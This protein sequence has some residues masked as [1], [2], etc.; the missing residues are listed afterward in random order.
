MKSKKPRYKGE[1]RKP[2][3]RGSI[4]IE[5]TDEEP[6][7]WIEQEII[8]KLPVLMEHYGIADKDDYR[9]LALALAKEHVRGFRVVRAALKLDHGTWGA[10]IGKRRPKKWPRERFL[11][12]LNAVD[13]AKRRHGFSTDREAIRFIIMH[14]G[15]WSRPNNRDEEKWLETMESRLQDAKRIEREE[16]DGGP[17]LD[18]ESDAILRELQEAVRLA[19]A[20]VPAATAYATLPLELRFAALC[21]PFSV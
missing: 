6:P 3:Y 10:V 18:P 16:R 12:L 1:L 21:L 15:E 17:A 11:R 19:R 13:E 9:S 5:R 8:E 7:E 4:P 20:T 14:K 2:I